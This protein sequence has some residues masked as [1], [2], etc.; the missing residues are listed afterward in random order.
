MYFIL[1]CKRNFM[2]KINDN[3]LN[4][5]NIANYLS[6]N[7]FISYKKKLNY[8]FLVLLYKK[9]LD[10]FVMLVY[11]HLYFL[12]MNL[13]CE[14]LKINSYFNWR[15]TKDFIIAHVRYGIFNKISKMKIYIKNKYFW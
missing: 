5:T 4:Q 6:K 15:F 12:D 8:L 1:F 3:W 2:N 7:S 10:N 14:R 11:E 9:I 13:F